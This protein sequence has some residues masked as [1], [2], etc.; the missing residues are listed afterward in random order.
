MTNLKKI[1][2]KIQTRLLFLSCLITL[3]TPQKMTTQF[4]LQD[5]NEIHPHSRLHFLPYT[6]NRKSQT[7]VQSCSKRRL[8]K[9][10][11]EKIEYDYSGE[12]NAIAFRVLEEGGKITDNVMELSFHFGSEV[13]K[14]FLDKFDSFFKGLKENEGLELSYGFDKDLKPVV[15][16]AIRTVFDSDG[17]EEKFK[18]YP[19]IAAKLDFFNVSF[20]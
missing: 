18:V 13:E 14:W 10:I 8:D 9:A 7:I 20:C 19:G 17:N 2:K 15:K 12:K 4:P 11:K 3:T 1:H 5:S 16:K 6:K